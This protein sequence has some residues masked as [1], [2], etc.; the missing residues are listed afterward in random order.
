MFTE[1]CSVMV[2]APLRSPIWTHLSYFPHQL[3]ATWRQS[4]HFVYQSPI[5][6]STAPIFRS[7]TTWLSEDQQIFTEWTSQ[8]HQDKNKEPLA[9]TLLPHSTIIII[10]KKALHYSECLF[11]M[12]PLL[13][14]S[15]T[16]SFFLLFY[17]VTIHPWLSETWLH[18]P[19]RR[20]Q[21]SLNWDLKHWCSNQ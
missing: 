7:V 16:E 12:Q 19:A 14:L 5:A 13:I 10:I 18:I 17:C 6:S 15:Q 8:T 9:V 11:S 3:K 1:V 2:T 21:K 4:S 20:Q